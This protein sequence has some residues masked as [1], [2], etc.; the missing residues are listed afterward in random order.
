VFA[1][2]NEFWRYEYN[3]DKAKKLLAEAGYPKGFKLDV[4]YNRANF[5]EPLVIEAKRYWDKIVDVDL[6]LIER[7]VYSKERKK[8]EHHITVSGGARYSPFLYAQ[9][10]LTGSSRNYAAYSNPKVDE[11]VKKAKTVTSEQESRK[12]W[13]EFQRLLVEDV[14]AIWM[15]NQQS[16]VAIRD[17]VKGIVVMPTPGLVI[18]ENASI[19]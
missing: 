19:E 16:Q 17:N 11:L 7:A 18:I 10:Y 5:Y 1:A 13:R 2:T 14:P 6:K 9:Y 12:Y 15:A 4:I 3:P 8:F